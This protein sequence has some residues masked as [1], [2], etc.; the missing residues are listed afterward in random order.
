MARDGYIPT[1]LDCL[2]RNAVV[3]ANKRSLLWLDKY[4]GGLPADIFNNIYS[5]EKWH[6]TM[7]TSVPNEPSIPFDP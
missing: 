1:P 6:L 2:D 7:L 5:F 4:G 3:D